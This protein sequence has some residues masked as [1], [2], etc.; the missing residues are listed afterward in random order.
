MTKALLYSLHERGMTQ[1]KLAALTGCG[2][3]HLSQV[4]SNKKG[5]GG[6]TRRKLIPHL[7]L[8]EIFMLGWAAEWH[9]DPKS[10]ESPIVPHRTNVPVARGVQS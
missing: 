5:R 9:F 10:I 8:E 6:Q 3:S 4:L 2:R 7:T 1:K